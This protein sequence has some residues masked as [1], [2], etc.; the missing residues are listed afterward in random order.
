[1]ITPSLACRVADA[2]STAG[3]VSLP[4]FTETISE[5]RKDRTW[6]DQEIPKPGPQK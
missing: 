1:V 6:L 4:A 2:V 3:R 5:L